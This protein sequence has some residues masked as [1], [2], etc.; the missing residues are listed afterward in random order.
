MNTDLPI[1][2]RVT[3]IIVPDNEARILDSVCT[4]SKPADIK[5]E[6]IIDWIL[7]VQSISA[8]NLPL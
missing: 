7:F 4:H 1:W 2:G 8:P 5:F 3:Q 6:Q